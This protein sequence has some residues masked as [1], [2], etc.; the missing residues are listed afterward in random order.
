MDYRPGR[1]T[2]L[3]VSPGEQRRALLL[4]LLIVSVPLLGTVAVVISAG[5]TDL[6][7]LTPRH[8][9]DN[10]HQ[11]ILDWPSLKRDHPHSLV[12]GRESVTFNGAAVRA[13]GYMA[14]A[15]RRFARGERVRDFIL[16]P[17]CGNLLHPAHR[18][19]DQ[20]IAVHLREADAFSFSPMALV[21]V[22]GTLQISSGDPGGSRPLY[23]LDQARS[24]VADKDDI[25]KY[26][27][28]R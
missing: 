4:I 5:D 28:L 16:L 20:M 9:Q 23:S 15:D 26:F 12:A 6:S 18:F 19:G 11:F 13:L 1:R 8:A 17:D 21:W 24:Q 25:H 10:N 7:D 27:Q 2:K 22:S 14:E 3:A